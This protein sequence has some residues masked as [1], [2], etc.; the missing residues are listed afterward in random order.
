MAE[1]QTLLDA[2]G[3]IDALRPV[4]SEFIDRV[5]ADVMIGFHFNA[6]DPDVLKQRELEFTARALGGDLPYSGRPM[7]QAHA[8]HPILPGQFYRRLTILRETLAAHH[9]PQPVCDAILLHTERLRGQ[10]LQMEDGCTPPKRIA[11]NDAK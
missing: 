6:V 2:M 1:K 10:I 4:I 7:R 3:G 11:D 8:Q 9:V 5:R